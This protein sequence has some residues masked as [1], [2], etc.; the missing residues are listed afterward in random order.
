MYKI[1]KSAF[2]TNSSSVHAFTI[3]NTNCKPTKR[4]TPRLGEYGWDFYTHSGEGFIDYIFT[5]FVVSHENELAEELLKKVGSDKELKD[6]KEGDFYVDH[7]DTKMKCIKEMIQKYG[8]DDVLF[9]GT[10]YT[11]NDNADCSSLYD[12]EYVAAQ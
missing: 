1:R 9:G 10:V 5:L 4:Y 2:E 11:G 3:C 8:F 7:A 6:Y 12:N